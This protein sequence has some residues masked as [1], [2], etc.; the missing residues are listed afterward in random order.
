MN[1]LYAINLKH[2]CLLFLC[3]KVSNSIFLKRLW[4][5]LQLHIK[6]Q[7]ITIKKNTKIMTPFITFVF[8]YMG[9]FIFRTLKCICTLVKNRRSH[10]ISGR[11]WLVIVLKSLCLLYSTCTCEKV[12]PFNVIT[13]MESKFYF[14][15]LFDH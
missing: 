13:S 3:I 10:G 11:C 8:K 15:Y 12:Y 6:N 2:I 7:I 14:F 1:F 4:G 9:A 5:K